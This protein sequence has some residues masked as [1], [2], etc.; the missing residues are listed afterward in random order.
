M[1]GS[2]F[3]VAS[4]D[5]DFV[6]P[7]RPALAGFLFHGR[8]DAAARTSSIAT[9]A[10]Q[11]RLATF[12]RSSWLT[13]SRLIR[14]TT[15]SACVP[16]SRQLV[17]VD[18]IGCDPFGLRRDRPASHLARISVVPSTALYAI[19]RPLVFKRADLLCRQLA[20]LETDFLVD[21][22]AMEV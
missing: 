7:S 4:T 5:G 13:L 1:S 11:V 10:M 21:G 2:L 15:D 14:E 22:G 8:V 6:A 9:D 12:R 16:A 20:G 18:R 3:Y 17:A 19:R